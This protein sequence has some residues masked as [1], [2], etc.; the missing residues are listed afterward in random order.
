MR[1]GTLA[2]TRPNQDQESAAPRSGATLEPAAMA[3]MFDDVAPTYDR[4]NT[5]MTLGSDVRWRRR[6]VDETHARLGDAVI[7][8]CCGTGKLA[9]QVAERVGPFGR[10]EGVDLSDEMIR[11]ATE[12]FHSLVQAH[13]G[14]A[15]AMELP[16][17]DGTFD[18]ATIG[19]GLRNLPDFE[20]GFREMARVVRPGG[21]VVCLELSLPKRRSIAR[22]YHAVFRRTAPLAARLLRGPRAAYAYLPQSLDGFPAPE[23]LC[24]AMRAAGLTDVRFARL[25][26]GMV[27]VHTGTVPAPAKSSGATAE[28]AASD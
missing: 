3:A 13:F 23:Q 25:S 12:H 9:A 5:V 14:V 27:A 8:V 10:V 19:F 18:A 24:D 15:N 16:F 4:L 2:R 20:G 21:R 17:D 1:S 7:D 26:G 6:A 28:A 11:L 22:L